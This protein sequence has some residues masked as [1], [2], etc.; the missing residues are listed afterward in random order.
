MTTQS[1]RFFKPITPMTPAEFASELRA[2]GL[3]KHEAA[4]RFGL[5]VRLIEHYSKGHRAGPNTT[6]IPVP[7]P[8]PLA[9]LLRLMTERRISPRDLDEEA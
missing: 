7:I 1:H 8:T 4:E 9:L 3:S 5:S 2:L 6:E